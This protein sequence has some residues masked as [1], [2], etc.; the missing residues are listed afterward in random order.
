M[1]NIIVIS[2]IIF[3][4][5]CAEGVT[6]RQKLAYQEYKE[7]KI[8]LENKNPDTALKLAFLP[9]GSSFYNSDYDIAIFNLFL[10]PVSSIW[11]IYN[12]ED[13]SKL[14]N[15]KLTEEN[16]LQKFR[17]EISDLDNILLLKKISQ[18]D[19][20][21][22]Y[23]KIF[24]KYQNSHSTLIDNYK[25]PVSLTKYTNSDILTFSDKKVDTLDFSSLQAIEP[26]ILDTCK[27]ELSNIKKELKNINE[28]HFLHN[29]QIEK[30]Q[31]FIKL[32]L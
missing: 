21:S 11:E 4:F 19:Y 14:I 25:L 16:I 5:S 22:S 24:Q 17:K 10:W 32:G 30:R 20:Y 2:V 7:K 23:N 8:L 6:R 26:K 28:Q 9:G 1:K 12:A 18:S 15:L 27:K 31:K 13:R 3:L 29:C